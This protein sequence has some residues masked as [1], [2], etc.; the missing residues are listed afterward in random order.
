[1]QV[2]LLVNDHHSMAK[3]GPCLAIGLG[4]YNPAFV[5]PLPLI[6]VGVGNRQV[7][8]RMRLAEQSSR[9]WVRLATGLAMVAT[10][11]IIVGWFVQKARG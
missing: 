4:L 10:L 3:V 5:V 1:M 2:V 11:V 8:Q 6:S 9:R 7:M